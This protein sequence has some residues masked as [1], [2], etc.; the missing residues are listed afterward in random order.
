MAATC[1]TIPYDVADCMS[2]PGDPN[3]LTEVSLHIL[4]S[5]VGVLLVL[6]QYEQLGDVMLAWEKSRVFEV[7]CVFAKN[8]PGFKTQDPIL[9][10]GDRQRLVVIQRHRSLD[11]L[12]E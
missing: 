6:V 4:Y 10:S 11:K 5:S 9:V 8:E 12:D 2:A 7:V 3:P 1:G